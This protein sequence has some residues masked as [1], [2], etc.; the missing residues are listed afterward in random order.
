MIQVACDIDLFT[1]LKTEWE[2]RIQCSLYSAMHDAIS[3][4]GYRTW[5]TRRSGKGNADSEASNLCSTEL[6]HQF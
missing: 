6:C 5:R 3:V 1:P 4:F 2:W